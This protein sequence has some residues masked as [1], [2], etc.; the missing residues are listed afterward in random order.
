[1]KK[2]Y[3]SRVQEEIYYKGKV[4]KYTYDA[5]MIYTDNVSTSIQ[6]IEDFEDFCGLHNLKDVAEE[7]GKITLWTDDLNDHTFKE[8]DFE[9]V[10][11][12]TYINPIP[13]WYSFAKVMNE[14]NYKDFI[15][16]VKDNE[17]VLGGGKWK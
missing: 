17:I 4:Y 7:T 15:D 12:T 1:M 13:E 11:V 3:W 9:K 6:E 5:H 14:L 10:V 16:F 2:L 8:K